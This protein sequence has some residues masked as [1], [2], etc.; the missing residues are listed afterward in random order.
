M[1]K[2][3]P[4]IYDFYI[5]ND[6][7]RNLMIDDLV[8]RTYEDIADTTSHSSELKTTINSHQLYDVFAKMCPRIVENISCLSLM[9]SKNIHEEPLMISSSTEENTMKMFHYHEVNGLEINEPSMEFY[10]DREN[11][12]LTPFYYS[13]QTMGIRYDLDDI[14]KE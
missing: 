4:D 10:I 8:G 6:E 9:Y 12:T 3:D 1:E 14:E 11:K 2:T 7:F 13:N 5:N